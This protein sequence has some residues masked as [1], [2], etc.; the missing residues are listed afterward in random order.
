MEPVIFAAYLPSRQS[1]IAVHGEEGAR[2]TF[3]I[4]ESD[5]VAAARLMLVR[6]KALKVTVEILDD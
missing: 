5:I 3:D 6:N 2:V 1:A 4:P